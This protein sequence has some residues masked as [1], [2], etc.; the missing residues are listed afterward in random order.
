MEHDVV[1]G[2]PELRDLGHRRPALQLRV[3]HPELG[4]LPTAFEPAT[5]KVA[6]ALACWR[7]V[8]FRSRVTDQDEPIRRSVARMNASTACAGALQTTCER[9]ADAVRAVWRV[10]S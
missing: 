9:W 10:L 2:F 8:N 4:E 1:E 3:E 5:D 7:I 6:A